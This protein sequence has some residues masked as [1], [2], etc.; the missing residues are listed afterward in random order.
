MG[1]GCRSPSSHYSGPTA[2]HSAKPQAGQRPVST[3]SG[4]PRARSEWDWRLDTAASFAVA[5]DVMT[6]YGSRTGQRLIFDV[7]R[8]SPLF[9]SQYDGRVHA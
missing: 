4:I 1:E 6:I 8:A 5:G 9:L 3:R 2:V 7:C